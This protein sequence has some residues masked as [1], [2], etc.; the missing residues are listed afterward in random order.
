MSVPLFPR[1]E[2]SRA[3]EPPASLKRQS[4]T[5][6]ALKYTKSVAG[7]LVIAVEELLTTTE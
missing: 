5:S 4:P 2:E 7:W 3:V 6:V 1:P